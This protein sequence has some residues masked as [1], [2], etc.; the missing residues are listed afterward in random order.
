MDPTSLDRVDK[1]NV[2]RM[3]TD[4]KVFEAVEVLLVDG[5]DNGDEVTMVAFVSPL[6]PLEEDDEG[7]EVTEP[8]LLAP[9]EG[10]ELTVLFPFMDPEGEEVTVVFAI[11]DGVELMVVV[12]LVELLFETAKVTVDDADADA[13]LLAVVVDVETILKSPEAVLLTVDDTVPVAVRVTVG[14]P[15]GIE[16]ILVRVAETEGLALLVVVEE[17]AA[18]DDDDGTD[19]IDAVAVEEYE[20]ILLLLAVG[21]NEAIAETVA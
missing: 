6:V 11:T 12:I 3:I 19:D 2:K 14:Y 15:P 5:E 18:D 13:V 8:T 20:G 7:E 1:S 17:R 21:D 10:V 9:D 16:G 4:G